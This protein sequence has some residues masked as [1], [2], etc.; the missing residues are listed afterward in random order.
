[1]GRMRREGGSEVGQGGGS[2]GGGVLAN[3][4]LVL[5]G[6]EGLQTPCGWQARNRS[7]RWYRR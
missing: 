7:A 1:M 5:V 2:G 4:D 3:L 6:G